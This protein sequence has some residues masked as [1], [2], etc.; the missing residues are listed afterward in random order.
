MI[1]FLI[2]PMLDAAYARGYQAGMNDA[3]DEADRRRAEVLDSVW[4]TIDGAGGAPSSA[5]AGCSDESATSRMPAAS[6]P[7]DRFSNDRVGTNVVSL[8]LRRADGKFHL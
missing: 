7:K 1:R 2:Q 4:K 8:H 3:L 6:T 5:S